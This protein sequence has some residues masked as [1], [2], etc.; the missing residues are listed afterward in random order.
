[1]KLMGLAVKERLDEKTGLEVCQRA[2]SSFG[3]YA[4]RESPSK[5]VT[6][7]SLASVG[8]VYNLELKALD[9]QTGESIARIETRAKNKDGV[10]GALNQAA[11][12][13]REGL[14]ECEEV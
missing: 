5:A 12:K 7:A 13:L 10:L 1:M 8:G 3:Q 9:C 6:A 2:K 11:T 14:G 4:P